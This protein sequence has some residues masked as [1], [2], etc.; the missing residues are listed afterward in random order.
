LKH[1]FESVLFRAGLEVVFPAER[2]GV[3]FGDE[4]ERGI[5]SMSAFSRAQGE[6]EWQVKKR[7]T[8]TIGRYI[9]V[10]VVIRWMSFV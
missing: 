9:R 6:I 8:C 5:G 1:E 3:G 2:E 10:H 4:S 7:L